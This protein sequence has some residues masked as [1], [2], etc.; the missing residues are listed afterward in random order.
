MSDTQAV[1]VARHDHVLAHDSFVNDWV[2]TTC[3][4]LQVHDEDMPDG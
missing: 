3:T 4:L 1:Q 2:C